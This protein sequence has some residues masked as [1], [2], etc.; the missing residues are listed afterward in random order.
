MHAATR[1]PFESIDRARRMVHR[2]GI[3]HPVNLG[4]RVGNKAVAGFLVDWRHMPV[5]GARCSLED[6]V[7]SR[8]SDRFRG[9]LPAG[10]AIG[11]QHYRKKWEVLK[12]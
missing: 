4:P 3:F 8:N 7:R 6:E 11:K 10:S 5:A 9:L 12:P 1:V 2:L